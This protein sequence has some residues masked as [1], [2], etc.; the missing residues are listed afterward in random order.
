MVVAAACSGERV[1]RACTCYVFS[2]VPGTAGVYTKCTRTVTSKISTVASVAEGSKERGECLSFVVEYSPHIPVPFTK[3]CHASPVFPK[4][5][6]LARRILAMRRAGGAGGGGAPPP[7]TPVLPERPTLSFDQWAR[8]SR[9][10]GSVKART[11]SRGS[12]ARSRR[13]AA[14]RRAPLYSATTA[15]AEPEDA[16]RGVHVAPAAAAYVW[17]AGGAADGGVEDPAPAMSAREAIALMRAAAA[18]AAAMSEWVP[19]SAGA[20]AAPAWVPAAAVAAPAAALAA[21]A[22]RADMGSESADMGSKS[23]RAPAPEARDLFLDGGDGGMHFPMGGGV[24]ASSV[25]RP[26]RPAPAPPRARGGDGEMHFPMGGR[27]SGTAAVAA[28][29]GPRGDAPPPGLPERRPPIG[30]CIPPSPPAPPGG[31]GRGGDAAASAAALLS[32]TRAKLLESSAR[33]AAVNALRE[34]R[35][36]RPMPLPPGAPHLGAAGGAGVDAGAAAAGAPA[37]RPARKP[38]SPSPSPPPSPVGDLL[39]RARPWAQPGGVTPGAAATTPAL[40]LRSDV[41]RAA[42]AESRGTPRPAVRPD[43]G[44]LPAAVAAAAAVDRHATARRP[45]ACAAPAPPPPV[46]QLATPARLGGARGRW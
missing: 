31:A 23:A 41:G 30:K 16:A 18:A 17:G 25:P 22:A 37:P 26:T 45:M 40:Q 19:V 44:T 29:A 11:P 39:S 38:P 5:I 6:S 32:A 33:A 3:R 1:A 46:P 43:D 4:C 13:P 28:A 24:A 36:A 42:L 15:A 20:A 7:A 8:L 35:G 9:S 34:A 27:R 2:L 21:S 12:Y 14:A 10:Y